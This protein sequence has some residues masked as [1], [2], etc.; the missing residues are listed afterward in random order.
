[1]SRVKQWPQDAYARDGPDSSP[2]PMRQRALNLEGDCHVPYT[3]ACGLK[4]AR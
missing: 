2:M 3:S 1:M 4:P